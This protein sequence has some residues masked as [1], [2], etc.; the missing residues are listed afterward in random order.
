MLPLTGVLQEIE[1]AFAV[2]YRFHEFAAAA[3]LLQPGGI[4][5]GAFVS[6]SVEPGGVET[7]EGVD[8]AYRALLSTSTERKILVTPALREA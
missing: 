2:Y 1:M 7:F 4:D 5:A 6:S 8:Q 3:D